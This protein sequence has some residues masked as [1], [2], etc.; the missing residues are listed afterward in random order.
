MEPVTLEIVIQSC[1]PPKAIKSFTPTHDVLFHGTGKKQQ[2]NIFYHQH[3][4]AREVEKLRRLKEMILKQKLKIPEDFNDC[5]LLK[6]VYGSN[7][8][9]KSAFKA[10]KACLD[11]RKEVL[12]DNFLLLYKNI[13]EILVWNK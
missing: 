7:F 3:F 6:F 4:S 9:T 13:V 5:E 11:S 12:T 2:R 10:V 8:K 1:E